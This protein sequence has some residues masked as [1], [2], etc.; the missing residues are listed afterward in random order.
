MRPSRSPTVL[1]CWRAGPGNPD[2]TPG[3]PSRET[4]HHDPGVLERLTER[5][6]GV[7]SELR[8][9]VQEQDT[10]MGQCLGMSPQ[11]GSLAWGKGWSPLASQMAP[12]ST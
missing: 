3:S 6:H 4:R 5:L 2:P 8:E 7:M 12:S 9:L 11:L 1:W 10:V